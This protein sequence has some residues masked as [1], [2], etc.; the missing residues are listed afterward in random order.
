MIIKP[1]LHH[2]CD[3]KKFFKDLLGG[4]MAKAVLPMKGECVPSL[5]EELRS[6]MPCGMANKLIR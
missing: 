2:Q 6:H 5:V 3:S 1:K 4:P